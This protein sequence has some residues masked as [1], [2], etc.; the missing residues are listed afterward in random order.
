[1]EDTNIYVNVMFKEDTFWMTQKAMA[2]LFE[3]TTD[4]ISLHLSKIS[5]TLL[6]PERQR[7]N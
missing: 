3:C 1:M 4:N 5:F 7:Q 6:L 2:D